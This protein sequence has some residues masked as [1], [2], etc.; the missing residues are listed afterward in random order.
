[1]V[2]ENTK[3]QQLE[4]ST[5]RAEKKRMAAPKFAKEKKFRRLCRTKSIDV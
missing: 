1:M 2:E 4:A 3:L 5:K